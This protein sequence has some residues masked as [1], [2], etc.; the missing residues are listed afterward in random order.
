MLEL[1]TNT[2]SRQIACGV[3]FEISFERLETVGKRGNGG[4]FNFLLFLLFY[5][6][7]PFS[8]SFKHE[9]GVKGHESAAADNFCTSQRYWGITPILALILGGFTDTELHGGTGGWRIAKR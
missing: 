6:C 3:N 8:W 4:Y 2:L 9:I 5:G 7:P 1:C